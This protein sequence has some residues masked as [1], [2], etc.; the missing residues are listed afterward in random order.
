MSLPPGP[1]PLPPDPG[2]PG[3][4]AQREYERRAATVGSS[5]DKM[6]GGLARASGK[7]PQATRAWADGA[8]GERK[9][10]AVLSHIPELR[11]LSDRRAG[12]ANLDFIVVGPAGVF[13]VDAKNYRGVITFRDD[14]DA[15]APDIRLYVDGRDR[16]YLAAEMRW[17]MKRVRQALSRS[18]KPVPWVTPVLCFVGGTWSI[19]LPPVPFD[20]VHLVSERSIIKLVTDRPVLDAGSVDRIHRVLG[21]AFPPR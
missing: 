17:Q 10:A 12:E 14:G 21:T 16:S 4:S 5:L 6:L 9:L 15:A 18:F 19:P 3:E 7:V 11:I 13:V 1:Q 20:G 2:T 8:I